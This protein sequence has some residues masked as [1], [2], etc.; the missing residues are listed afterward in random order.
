MP[1]T[2][3]Q[4][5]KLYSDGKITQADAKK[6]MVEISTPGSSMAATEEVIPREGVRKAA[7]TTMELMNPKQEGEKG[8]SSIVKTLDDL[9]AKGGVNR[10]SR[11]PGNLGAGPEPTP[12]MAGTYQRG[13]GPAVN[14]TIVGA[15]GVLA[16]AA[17]V[18]LPF[19]AVAAP[20]ATA[21][22]LGGGLLGGAAG[23]PVTE[24]VGNFL[25][26]KP[27]EEDIEA[28]GNIGGLLGGYAP[29]L[30]GKFARRPLLSA[31]QKIGQAWQGRYAKYVNK[32]KEADPLR[33]ELKIALIKEQQAPI[34]AAEELATAKAAHDA[35]KR[36]LTALAEVTNTVTKDAKL[37]FEKYKAQKL[38]EKNIRGKDA[39]AADIDQA[40]AHLD[41]VLENEAATDAL[42]AAQRKAAKSVSASQKE[43]KLDLGTDAMELDNTATLARTGMK[44][45][46]SGEI[47]PGP[48]KNKKTRL[49]EALEATFGAK[50]TRNEAAGIEGEESLADEVEVL[51][52]E[53]RAKETAERLA[54]AN[55]G[56]ISTKGA[57]RLN[58]K[59]ELVN[60][61]DFDGIFGNLS[62]HRDAQ[63]RGNMSLLDKIDILEAATK[64]NASAPVQ[65][66]TYRLD[67]EEKIANLEAEAE[68]M[69]PGKAP[70]MP[71]PLGRQIA[72]NIPSILATAGTELFSHNPGASLAA[73]GGAKLAMMM[74]QKQGIIK[75]PKPYTAAIAPRIVTPVPS[76]LR[77]FLAGQSG[78]AQ[79]AVP[80]LAALSEYLNNLRERTPEA[81][82]EDSAVL[83]NDEVQ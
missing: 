83:P 41:A 22:S 49:A 81:Q 25:G 3:T 37:A 21:L 43:Q 36:R 15:G 60:P 46:E 75:S 45:T 29:D 35:E 13:V 8:Y 1:L 5:L 55:K 30:A 68:T 9:F 48:A 58:E 27:N 38:S 32:L 18:A 79:G 65:A 77:N 57:V 19:G 71:K 34:Q 56:R 2:A 12:S 53:T 11:V 66:K 39:I 52:A 14:N 59:G 20:V 51:L 74:L 6:L 62:K 76:K 78:G 73:G 80:G 64:K 44:E 72:E 4:V 28:G 54:L 10:L 61:D 67:L 82:P 17:A 26:F 33:P 40:K 50:R 47:V 23:G 31:A 7:S 69:R 16:P 70:L 42:I 63:R 24:K